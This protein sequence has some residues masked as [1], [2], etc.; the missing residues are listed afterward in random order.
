MTTPPRRGTNFPNLPKLP[1]PSAPI[2][3]LVKAMTDIQ[4]QGTDAM[5][6][7]GQL[8]QDAQEGMGKLRAFIKTGLGGPRGKA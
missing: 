3:A 5:Q 1:D 7:A 4:E 2:R 6:A 8:K